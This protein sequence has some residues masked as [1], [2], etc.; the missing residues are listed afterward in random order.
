MFRYELHTINKK[1][2][3]TD[4]KRNDVQMFGTHPLSNYEGVSPVK[5]LLKDLKKG[6][7]YKNREQERDEIT[8]KCQEIFVPPGIVHST[9]T[10][11]KKISTLNN[12]IK[13]VVPSD[14]IFKR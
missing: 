5:D 4:E 9:E 13:N 7:L 14:N 1:H 3:F 6:E 11:L 8:K 2:F 12:D 10:A